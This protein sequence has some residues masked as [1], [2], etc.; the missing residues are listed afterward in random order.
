VL[1]RFGFWPAMIGGLTLYM[2]CVGLL[3]M[4]LQ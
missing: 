3:K 4:M 2:T 1:P